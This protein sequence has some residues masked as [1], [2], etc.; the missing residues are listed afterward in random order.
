M[1]TII[2][3]SL[4]MM[5]IYINLLIEERFEKGEESVMTLIAGVNK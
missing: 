4:V 3:I 1:I 2:I 5:G